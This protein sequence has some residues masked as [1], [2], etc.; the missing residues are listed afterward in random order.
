[1]REVKKRTDKYD[2]ARLERIESLLNRLDNYKILFD[3]EDRDLIR[4]A[5]KVHASVIEMSEGKR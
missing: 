5:L 2:P 4:D 3:G 1:M